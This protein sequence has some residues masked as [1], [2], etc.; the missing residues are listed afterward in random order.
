MRS[1]CTKLSWRQH[2]PGGRKWGKKC[3]ERCAEMGYKPCLTGMHERRPTSGGSPARRRV[4][5]RGAGAGGRKLERM[6]RRVGE[7]SGQQGVES[8]TPYAYSAEST[9]R[10]HTNYVPAREWRVMGT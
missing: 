2:P 1:G 6:A 8:E 5:S 10:V 4:P 7:E 3:R 9:L